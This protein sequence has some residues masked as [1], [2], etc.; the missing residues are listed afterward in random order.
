MEV[1]DEEISSFGICNGYEVGERTI[2][3]S[4]MIEKPTL[5]AAP[6]NTAIVGRYILTPR[7]FDLLE[8]TQ[9]GSGGEIQL[10]D[11]MAQLREEEGIVGYEFKGRRYDTGDQFGFLRA[12]IDFALK[13][14]EL[15]PRL[16]EYMK[17]LIESRGA[18]NV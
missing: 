14:K 7:I 6:S 4:E 15:E 12:N 17:S 5:D 18:K 3:I 8:K 11:A 1:E 13:R 16:L 10:T 9:P 2:E